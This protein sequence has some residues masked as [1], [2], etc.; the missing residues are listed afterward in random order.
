MSVCVTIHAS[1]VEKLCIE[2]D[3]II[4]IEKKGFD[5]DKDVSAEK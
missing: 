3:H 2:N 4:K 1:E 5:R